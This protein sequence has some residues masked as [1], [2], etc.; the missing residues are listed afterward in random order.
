MEP[1][2]ILNGAIKIFRPGMTDAEVA[3]NRQTKAIQ[4]CDRRRRIGRYDLTSITIQKTVATPN[5]TKPGK[6]PGTNGKAKQKR[7][8]TSKSNMTRNHLMPFHL[9]PL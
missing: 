6:S 2:G 3:R 1:V 9:S 5:N 4:P 7:P 8:P